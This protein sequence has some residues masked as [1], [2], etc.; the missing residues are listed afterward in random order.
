MRRTSQKVPVKE[1]VLFA[2]LN[3]LLNL[4]EYHFGIGT[5]SVLRVEP[6]EQLGTT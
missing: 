2:V 6:G 4:F 1:S 3:L 5:T